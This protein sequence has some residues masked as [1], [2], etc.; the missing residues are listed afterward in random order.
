MGFSKEDLKAMT[1]KVSNIKQ[2]KKHLKKLDR[3]N[4]GEGKISKGE[5]KW[6]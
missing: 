3:K 2:I 4:D 6:N 5:V 1:V